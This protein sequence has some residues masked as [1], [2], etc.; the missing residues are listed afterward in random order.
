[1]I[2]DYLYWYPWIPVIIWLILYISDYY[3]TIWGAKLY[4]SQHVVKLEGSYELT[5]AYIKDID[6]L[7]KFSPS[8]LFRLVFGTFVLLFTLI[9]I[10]KAPWLYG[11]IVGDFLFV[12]LAIHIRHFSNIDTYRYYSKI[13]ESDITG[14]ISYPKVIAYKRSSNQLLAFG[15]FM[16]ITYGM[17]LNWMILGGAIGVL[18]LAFNHRMLASKSQ[19]APKTDGNTSDGS[20]NVGI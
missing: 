6:S 18:H 10:R 2:P 11:I 9:L 8:F 14:S 12:E 19:P 1:M 15:I 4:R 5:P 13:K 16:F 7:R 17:T 20:N 3:L